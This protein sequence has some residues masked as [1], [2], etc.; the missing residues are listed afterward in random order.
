MGLERALPIII[1]DNCWFGANVTVLQGVTIGNG[2]V[3]AAGSVVTK[4]V[5]DNAMI[6]GVPAAVKKIIEQ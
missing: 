5:P 6:A 1:G 2:C 3:I 4:D